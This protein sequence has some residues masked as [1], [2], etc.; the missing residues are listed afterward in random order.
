MSTERPDNDATDPAKGHAEGPAEEAPGTAAAAAP[1]DTAAD[2]SGDR[3]EDTAEERAEDPA[4][5]APESAVADSGEGPA[6]DRAEDAVAEPVRGEAEDPAENHA[7]GPA[8]HRADVPAEGAADG[9]VEGAADAAAPGTRDTVAGSGGEAGAG[10]GEGSSDSPAVPAVSEGPVGAG[11]PEGAGGSGDGGSG[12]ESG[13]AHPEVAVLGAGPGPVE[14]DGAGGGRRR[15]SPVLLASVVA[16]VLLVGGGGAY[17]ASTASGSARSAAPGAEDTAPP[18]LVLDGYTAS[19]G[20]TGGTAG[21][22]PGEPDPYG[23]T[24]RAKGALPSGPGSA[25]VR[26]A[27]G[28]VTR[29][30]VT[31]LAK[32][33]GLAGTPRLAGDAWTVGSVKDGTEPNLRVTADAPGTWT[34][35]SALPGGDNCVKVTTCAPGDSGSPAGSAQ[36]PVSEATAR[37]AAAP[38]LKA[39]GQDGAKLDA[40]QLMGRVRV[41]NADP[42]VGGLPTYGWTTGLRIGAS[43][44]VVGGSG[45]LK[46]TVE[47][48]AYPV[49]GARKTLDEMNGSA[50]GGDRRMGIGGCASP[51][52]L[53]DRDEM[54]CEHPSPAEPQSVTVEKATFGLAAQ[55]AN[56]R[57]ALVPSWLFEVRS[58]GARDTY[59]VTRPAVD[60][61]FLASP[62]SPAAPS[63]EP[64]VPVP[65]GQVSPPAA[66]HGVA[67]QG[68]TADGRNLKVYFTGGV[69]ADYTVSA[70]ESSGKV[71]VTVT[72]KPWKN[73][74]CIMIAKIYERTVRLDA[75]LGDREV[76]GSDG[77]AVHH[78]RFG[79]PETSTA[80][81]AD[82]R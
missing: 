70:R 30:E 43:G 47:G 18:R 8:E 53:K 75:P 24:Y 58:P 61:A 54:P 49:V 41:V 44:H 50:A 79:V 1:E 51:V 26:W 4:G 23:T 14:G 63:T 37:K 7:E 32:A 64:T 73:K 5:E 62:Q 38:V 82:P 55:R 39:V 6:G 9:T 19:T 80:T 65:S 34:F 40:S 74:V 72:E 60:P 21:I 16:A 13:E 31:R 81:P 22:A 78:G 77:E 66:A 27:E 25:H 33:L 57:Q 20:G 76:V 10:S 15:H 36:D 3:T 67:V 45:Q 35:A 59:T 52:P 69:C 68:Y 28:R 2:P 12:E 17:V 29:A 42:V 56:G 71:T 46:T 11:A 48:D